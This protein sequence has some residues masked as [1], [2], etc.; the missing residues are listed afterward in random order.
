ML[1]TIRN[2]NSSKTSLYRTSFNKLSNISTV[3]INPNKLTTNCNSD[4]FVKSCD[5]ISFTG[6]ST[7]AQ[8][9][10]PFEKEFL[11]YCTKHKIFTIEELQKIVKKYLP[12]FDVKNMSEL[13][14]NANAHDRTGAYIRDMFYFTEKGEVVNGEKELY[15]YLPINTSREELVRFHK[16]FVHEITHGFQETSSDRTSKQQWLENFLE[17][18][19]FDDKTMNILRLFPKFFTMVEYNVT[20]PLAEFLRKENEIPTPINDASAKVLDNI[21]EKTTGVNVNNYIDYIINATANKLG[22]PDK[23]ADQKKLM[24]YVNLIAQKELEAHT[25]GINFSKKSE[26]I[27]SP[28]DLDLLIRLYEKLVERTNFWIEVFAQNK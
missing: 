27:T 2:N 21:F 25:K 10:E 20:L 14:N 23:C 7:F 6:I 18:K 24:E 17:N 11:E 8:K 26:K 1:N 9:F 28:T 3:K 16:S 13:N 12:N 19:N 5:N 4:V 22:F 15:L